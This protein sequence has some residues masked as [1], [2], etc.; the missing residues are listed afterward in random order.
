MRQGSVRGTVL[1]KTHGY[2]SYQTKKPRSQRQNFSS[3]NKFIGSMKN[4][5]KYI[6][7]MPVGAFC[8][9]WRHRKRADRLSQRAHPNALLEFFCPAKTVL[10]GAGARTGEI[11]RHLPRINDSER[12]GRMV[13]CRLP[14]QQG[15]LLETCLGR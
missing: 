8:S 10:P 7:M 5:G 13:I 15:T 14:C 12:L 1:K 2:R 6:F 4:T 9:T 11:S 3:R